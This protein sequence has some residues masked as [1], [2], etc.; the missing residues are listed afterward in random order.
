MIRVL[1]QKVIRVKESLPCSSA[2]VAAPCD[3][4]YNMSEE[5]SRSFFKSERTP[6]SIFHA[7]ASGA[8]REK[9]RDADYQQ[10]Q[11]MLNTPVSSFFSSIALNST[12]SEALFIIR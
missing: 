9:V 1:E 7:R 12:D 10:G 3:A 8:S 4:D 2:R 6:H 5:N 11:K